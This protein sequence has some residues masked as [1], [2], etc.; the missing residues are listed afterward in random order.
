MAHVALELNNKDSMNFGNPS[1]LWCLRSAETER[2]SALSKCLRNVL[3]SKGFTKLLRKDRDLSNT[4]VS[5]HAR[6]TA[7][8]ADSSAATARDSKSA[9]RSLS[10]VAAGGMAHIQQ[11]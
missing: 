11:A 5:S 1:P 7:R 2:L 9:Q 4:S 8:G 10:P 6:P 3:P